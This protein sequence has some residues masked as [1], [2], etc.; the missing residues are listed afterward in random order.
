MESM[1]PEAMAQGALETWTASETFKHIDASW[2]P[3]LLL[4]LAAA[5]KA[6]LEASPQQA[7]RV[8]LITVARSVLR[9]PL[10]VRTALWRDP[11]LGRWTAGLEAAL[12]DGDRNRLASLL[13][14]APRFLVAAALL[15]GS[16]AECLVALGPS[17]RARIPVDGR[18]L[19]GPPGRLIRVKVTAGEL[20]IHA[21]APRRAGP[22]EVVDEDA[23]LGSRPALAPLHGDS[24]PEIVEPL[25]AG[26]ACLA[27]TDPGL[28]SEI[29]ALAPVLV[30]LSGT[31]DVSLSGS[32]TEARGCIWL[33]PVARPLVVAETLVHESSHLKFFC[34]E[35]SAP[36]TVEEDPPRFVVPWRSDLRP[37]RA[38]LMGLHAWVRVLEWLDTLDQGPYGQAARERAQVLGEATAAAAGIVSGADG[39]TPPGEALVRRLLVGR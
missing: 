39:L 27:A 26:V 29:G 18:V 22:L 32:L 16:D 10:S 15:G 28:L 21:R 14:V 38:V 36:W 7:Q 33:T 4:R 25:A 24:V 34:L 20:S 23:E 37:L 30:A 3:Q 31:R 5:V 12:N 35:D 8:G 11:A 6:A 17:G 2:G 1:T 9:G 13:A 19:Q